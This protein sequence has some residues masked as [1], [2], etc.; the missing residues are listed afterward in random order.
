MANKIKKDA[1]NINYIVV[2][3]VF[4]LI[5]NIFS[6]IILFYQNEILGYTT[7][8]IFLFWQIIQAIGVFPLMNKLKKVFLEL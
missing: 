1:K 8:I 6:N 4:S 5:Y 7:I 2:S 3:C